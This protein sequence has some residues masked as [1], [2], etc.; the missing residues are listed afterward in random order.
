M[1]SKKSRIIIAVSLCVFIFGCVYPDSQDKDTRYLKGF[2][3]VFKTKYNY[4]ATWALNM[5]YFFV[6]CDSKGTVL[7]K[8]SDSQTS[9]TP[10]GGAG[11]C[12]G[13]RNKKNGY[14]YSLV[15]IEQ[16]DDRGIF[17]F[18]IMIRYKGKIYQAK[19]KKLI[20]FNGKKTE[21]FSFNMNDYVKDPKLSQKLDEYYTERN[22]RH[23][24]RNK[25]LKSIDHKDIVKEINARARTVK[26]KSKNELRKQN[27]APQFKKGSLEKYWLDEEK[28][29]NIKDSTNVERI[30]RGMK[31][32]LF[33]LRKPIAWEVP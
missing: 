8:I 26:A 16:D 9:F 18:D 13:V 5:K 14:D 15:I 12:W 6:V 11:G 24:N 1:M 3:Q 30:K 22:N 4:T 20:A 17:I 33:L 7:D 25:N 2:C 31:P 23:R 19:L 29:L 10:Q 28:G 21:I 27:R 32:V